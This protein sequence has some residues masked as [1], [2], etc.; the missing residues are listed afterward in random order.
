MEENNKK[1]GKIQKA[2]WGMILLSLGLIVVMFSRTGE[3]YPADPLLKM[4]TLTKMSEG[5][6]IEPGETFGGEQEQITLPGSFE[7][8][9]E[10]LT[11]RRQCTAEEINKGILLVENYRQYVTVILGGKT[12]Y[13]FPEEGNHLSTSV[14]EY[15]VLKVDPVAEDQTLEI[16][17]SNCRQNVCTVMEPIFCTPSEVF[18]HLFKMDAFSLVMIILFF[19]LIFMTGIFVLYMAVR[20]MAEKRV[21][22][23]Y[24]LLLCLF[25]WT[26]TGMWTSTLFPVSDQLICQINYTAI[27]LLPV[28]IGLFAYYTTKQYRSKVLYFTTILSILNIIIQYALVNLGVKSYYDMLIVTHIL[29]YVIAAMSIAAQI[30]DYRIEKSTHGKLM[31][32]TF[33]IPLVGALLAVS[34]F[35]NSSGE[36]YSI[37]YLLSLL[38]FIVFMVIDACY[39]LMENDFQNR[40]TKMEL[41]VYQRLSVIDGLTGLGNRRAFDEEM[42]VVDQKR[43][44]NAL[45][46]FLDVNGLKDINDSYGHKEGDQVISGAAQCIRTTFQGIGKCYRLGGD[47][48]GVIIENPE[49]TPED[50]RN[51]LMECIEHYNY[52][53]PVSLSIAAGSSYLFNKDHIKRSLSLWKS[54]ADRDMY[55]DKMR[56]KMMVENLE[57][58][59]INSDSIDEISGILTL[60]GF[61]K[62][63]RQLICQYPNE[64]YSLWYFN[65]KKF[66]FVND[67]LGYRVGDKLIRYMAQMILE[68]IQEGETCGHMSGDVMLVLAK[69]TKDSDIFEYFHAIAKN[70]GKFFEKEEISFRTEIAAGVYL[71]KPEDVK[72]LDINQ[73]LDWAHV[74]QKSVKDMIG[75][76]YAVFGDEM[77]ER[78]WKELYI[79]QTLD[80]ALGTGEI[81]VWL[82]PQYDYQT[83]RISGAEALCRWTHSHLGW[84]S[85]GE[86]IPA[87][88]KTGQIQKLDFY[89]WE[90]VC[91]LMQRWRSSATML[92]LSVSVNVSRLDVIEG[93]I[94]TRLN[95]LTNKYDL[96]AS[97]LRLEITEG[98]YMQRPDVL[99][100][101]VDQL[102]DYGYVVEM[103]DFGSGYSSLNMLKEVEVDGIK[104]DVRSLRGNFKRDKTRKIVRAIVQ[105]SRELGI[106]VLSEGVENEEQA[107]FLSSI[108]CNRMQGYYFSRP[109]VVEEFEQLLREEK[110]K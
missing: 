68:S 85:P 40:K 55:A 46:F 35:W 92:P 37:C 70:M 83:G 32:V 94:I 24:G 97:A 28:F 26:V 65:I 104:M 82:Q 48:F 31:I 78:Q 100:N 27:M 12:I 102:H 34:L 87:L 91:K 63:A 95:E 33:T 108:G 60:E 39:S 59:N 43:I 89:V 75:N 76:N 22:Y 52:G 17:F 109:M 81:S 62:N 5:W 54:N 99:I 58:Q 23:L 77:W 9:G 66:K 42:E 1:S 105:M 7:M 44:E 84:L 110:K 49:K 20:H 15:I 11:I 45:L 96:P 25:T 36:A 56:S 16:C 8:T 71:V 86:F 107:Q 57:M 41:E 30:C 29:M 80:N 90:E 69:K 72:N 4:D 67:F 98:A 3:R 18:V 14:N 101:V 53:R 10:S 13:S 19:F 74:A 47:E 51:L 88:E 21:L 64:K 73:M 50:Y 103:D 61:R 106:P 2:A 79:N 6:S 38:I 93:D